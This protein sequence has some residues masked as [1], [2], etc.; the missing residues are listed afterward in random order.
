LAL[1]QSRPAPRS[2]ARLQGAVQFRFRHGVD[3]NR[4]FT[5][6]EAKG[7]VQIAARADGDEN[8]IAQ[9]NGVALTEVLQTHLAIFQFA[10]KHV[11]LGDVQVLYGAAR[12]VFALG[13]A[14]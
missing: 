11:V 9:A 4:G 7:R 8:P 13:A 10:Q 6:G 5:D 14:A 12:H 2:S 1:V 3:A